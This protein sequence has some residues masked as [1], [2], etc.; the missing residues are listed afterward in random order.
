VLIE[1]CGFGIGV[2]DCWLGFGISVQLGVRISKFPNR[3]SPIDNP[4][5]NRQSP[6][7]NPIANRQSTIQIG[8]P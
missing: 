7:D 4:I 1:I 6:I 3:Q 5:A 8:N 2:D